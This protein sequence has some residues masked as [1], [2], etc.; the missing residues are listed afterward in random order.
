MLNQLH[1]HDLSIFD[2]N[3]KNYNKYSIYIAQN[4]K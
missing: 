2:Y 1:D 4:I 3:N